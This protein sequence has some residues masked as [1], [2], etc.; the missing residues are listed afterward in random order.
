MN[1]FDINNNFRFY[2]DSRQAFGT[3]FSVEKR[4][5]DWVW[6]LASVIATLVLVW[7]MAGRI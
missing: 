6:T 3:R 4:G 5:R 1:R 7:V 2:R